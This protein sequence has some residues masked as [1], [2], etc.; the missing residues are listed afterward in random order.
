MSRKH[1]R[2]KDSSSS[3]VSISDRQTRTE[4]SLVTST[5]SLVGAWQSKFPI[6]PEWNDAEI[7]QEKWESCKAEDGK[8][9][10]GSHPF[11]E[12]PE[13]KVPLPPSLKVHRWN[14]PTEFITNKTPNVVENPSTFD[15]ISSN[16]H[17]MCSELIRWII[18]EIYILWT[19][20]KSVSA[21]QGGWKPWE[22]IYSL[23]KVVKGHVPRYNS[24]GKYVVKLYWMGC[25]RKVTVDDSMP[26]DEGNKLLLP[27]T[28]C[29]SELWPMLLAKALIKLANT[30]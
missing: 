8:P 3:K 25:W 28:T 27:A 29:Q 21:E 22:H 5:E 19:Q 10:K 13:G 14:R 11:F 9:T 23:C 1:A 7:N 16:D 30:K 12:D 18:S 20:G 26:F 4:A 24:Y 15:L 2:K 6:W 17:L